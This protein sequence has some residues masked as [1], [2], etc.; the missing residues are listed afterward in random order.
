MEKNDTTTRKLGIDW[1]LTIVGTIL[2]ALVSISV[3]AF[4]DQT[5]K[6]AAMLQN[7]VFQ[8]GGAIIM[9]ITMLLI[10]LTIWL[11][12]SK[13]G[14]LK[15]GGG[16]A[17]Y[18]KP[19]FFAMMICSGFGA[20]TMYWAFLETIYY[21]KQPGLNIDPLSEQ[22]AEYALAYNMFHWGPSGWVFGTILT[23]V[24]CFTFYFKKFNELRYSAICD[25]LFGGIPNWSKKSIDLL[26]ILT[27]VGSSAISLGLSIPLISIC[28]THLTGIPS[29]TALDAGLVLIIGGV[30]TL[31]SYTGLKKGLSKLASWNIYICYAFLAIILIGGPTVFILNN[32][33]TAF[34][35]FL[36]KF[37][38][39]S[40]YTNPYGDD[41]FWTGWTIFYIAYWFAFAPFKALFI[42]KIAKGHTLRDILLIGLFAGCF[43]GWFIFSVCGSYGLYVQTT[44]AVDA[45]TMLNNG[46]ANFALLEILKTFPLAGVAIALFTFV[47]ILFMATTMDSSS[48]SLATATS[49]KLDKDGNPNPIFRL[50]WCFILTALPLSLV[51]AQ[52][53]LNTIKTIAA[54]LCVPVG[55][56]VLV[57]VYKGVRGYQSLFGHMSLGDIAKYNEEQDNDFYAQKSKEGSM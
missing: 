24:V 29:S 13:Y 32:T 38:V 16:E 26:F 34:G 27:T 7:S 18:S 12:F 45:V 2:I 6:T 42:T 28:V 35:I 33:T 57:M 15:L 22:A 1:P 37:F 4:P 10:A 51:I 40:T 3:T 44:G 19:K 41:P 54:M 49:S 50:F 30:F 46:Q 52:S 14:S 8:N 36:D 53:P 5:T 21:Y 55:I 25:H 20:A 31:S 17:D 23:A 43:G 56:L 47:S 48:F 9:W 39:M 11:A